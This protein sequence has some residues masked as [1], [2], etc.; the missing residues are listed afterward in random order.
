MEHK[1]KWGPMRLIGKLWLPHNPILKLIEHLTIERQLNFSILRY[2][3]E[4]KEL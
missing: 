4:I 2:Y 1:L 3:N